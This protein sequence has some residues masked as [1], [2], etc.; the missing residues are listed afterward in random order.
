MSVKETVHQKK[1]VGQMLRLDG[2]FFFFANM[3]ELELL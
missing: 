2:I 1:L 3:A